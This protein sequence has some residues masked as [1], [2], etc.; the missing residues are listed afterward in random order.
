MSRWP[1]MATRALYAL[2]FLALPVGFTV[3]LG[4]S[5]GIL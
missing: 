4:M 3:G 2:A 1:Q 5:L